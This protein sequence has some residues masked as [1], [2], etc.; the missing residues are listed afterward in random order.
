[1]RTLV[2]APLPIAVALGDQNDERMVSG[3][4]SRGCAIGT[5]AWRRALA[6][7]H[8]HLALARGFAQ[9]EIREVQVER[10]QRALEA[11]FRESG[12][13]PAELASAP[14]SAPWKR[15]L[16]RQLRETVAPPYASLAGNLWIG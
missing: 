15:V 14:K 2:G 16:A 13:A 1:M 9:E 4:L 11:A 7:E 10:W 12:R 5:A 6:R 3:S 8:A